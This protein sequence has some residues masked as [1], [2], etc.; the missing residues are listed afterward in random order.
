[1]EP[2]RLG[3]Y[4]VEREIGRGAMGRVYLAHDPEIDRKVAVKTVLIPEA[5]GEEARQRFLREARSVGKLLHPGIVTIFDVGE[6]GNLLYLAMEYV[7]GVTFDDYCKAENLL[8][9]ETVCTLV[10]NVADALHFAHGTGLVHRDVKPANLMRVGESSV[11]VMDFGLAK[12]VQASMTMDGALL[13]TPSYMSPEQ[14]RGGHVDA[15]SDLFSLGVVLFEMLTGEKPFGGDSISAIIYRIVNEPPHDASQLRSRVHPALDAF[16][17]RSLAKAPEER[18]GG[19][20]EFAAK[21]REALRAVGPEEAAKTGRL[22]AAD[23]AAAAGARAPTGIDPIT[24]EPR[25][26]QPPDPFADLLGSGGSGDSG[27]AG[28]SGGARGAG[29]SGGA[30]PDD[31][32]PPPASKPRRG[33]VWPYV[34]VPLLLLA[35]GVGGAFAFREELGIDWFD[36]LGQPAEVWWEAAVRTEPAGLPVTL[37]GEPVEG[38]TVRFRPEGPFGTLRAGEACRVAEH[39]IR[40]AD[41][42]GEI[43]LFVDPARLAWT[44][45]PPQAG[46]RV[47]VNGEPA[48]TAPVELDLDLCRENVVTVSAEGFVERSVEIP[49]GATPLEARTLLNGVTLAAIPKGTLVLPE[50]A[51]PLVWY[52]DGE[53]VGNGPSELQLEQGSHR[54][55]AVNASFWIDVSAT[56]DVPADG[57]ATADVDVPG[58]AD[59]AVQAFPPN[60]KVYL[61]KPGAP[62]WTYVDDTPARLRIAAGRYEVRVELKTSGETRDSAVDL[63]PGR[64]APLRVSFARNP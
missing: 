42:G 2:T 9:V 56:V 63:E 45:E 46:A 21:L 26:P 55:R 51:V 23:A 47:A 5:E 44:F 54:V 3:R 31:S 64:N 12:P 15:R 11:K 59:L 34:V 28:S 22:A 29:A 38:A 62:R 33:R 61:R 10:A 37:D 41:A 16:L 43:V 19:G 40:P 17:K 20:A 7:E 52:V 8:P 58:L 25:G 30:D 49:Q 36:T 60:C 53:R 48:G 6:S 57:R 4:I 24:G 13:G 1:M 32:V 18:F 50:R 39:E 14:I 27:G 35:A